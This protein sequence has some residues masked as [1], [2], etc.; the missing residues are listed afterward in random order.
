MDVTEV[1]SRRTTKAALSAAQHTM[2]LPGR[3][4][5]MLRKGEPMTESNDHAD[6]RPESNETTAEILAET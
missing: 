5:P 2:H 1:P 4:A 6:K 3:Q